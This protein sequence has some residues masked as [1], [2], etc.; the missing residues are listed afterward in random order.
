MDELKQLITQLSE[1]QKIEL[2]EK[3]LD[4]LKDREVPE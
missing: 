3:I 1:E 4:M 2:L